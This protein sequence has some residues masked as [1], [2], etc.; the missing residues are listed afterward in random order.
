MWSYL[1]VLSLKSKGALISDNC[2]LSITTFVIGSSSFLDPYTI[3]FPHPRSEVGPGL[4]S[5]QPAGRQKQRTD[6]FYL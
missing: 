3:Y 6:V 2:Y 1:E 4:N 5:S